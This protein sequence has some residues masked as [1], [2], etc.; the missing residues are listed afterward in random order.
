[1][2]S[3]QKSLS[4]FKRNVKQRYYLQRY[5]KSSPGSVEWLIGAEIKYGGKV[6][7]VKRN[8]V[9]PF[10]PRTNEHLAIGGC[11][12]GDRMLGSWLCII[13]FLILHSYIQQSGD[14]TTIC[15]FGILKGTGLAIWCDSIPQW[16]MHWLRH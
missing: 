12:G 8:R 13:L 6:R 5:L 2:G 1:M 14:R 16:Q 4:S 3:I 7:G 15:E 10:D 9:S 11:M